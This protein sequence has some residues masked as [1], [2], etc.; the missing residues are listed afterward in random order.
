MKIKME[1]KNYIEYEII[2]NFI[3]WCEETNRTEWLGY[4]N[5][6]DRILE[7]Y[8]EEKSF[9]KDKENVS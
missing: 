3:E 5:T 8:F 1:L 2:K 4:Y 6:A 9:K 7:T